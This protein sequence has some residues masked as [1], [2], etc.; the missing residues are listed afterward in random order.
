MNRSAISGFGPLSMMVSAVAWALLAT[1]AHAADKSGASVDR[2]RYIVK[3]G[4]CNDCHTPGFAQANGQIDERLWLTG[5]KV[6][7]QGGWGTT[8]AIN[9]RQF[10]SG[11]TEDQWVQVT[12]ASQAKPPM[13]VWVFR[14]MT[15][16][17][18]RSV[19]RFIR[20]LGPAGEAAPTYL[21][22]GQATQ[23]P[24]IKFPQ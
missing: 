13:P 3:V 10:V 5:D 20:A 8:F 21:P 18:L 7:W 19:Y 22:P 2:G 4:G 16:T 12:R 11:M 15:E 9:I 1:S 14:D 24:A 6:G 23:L 17:D